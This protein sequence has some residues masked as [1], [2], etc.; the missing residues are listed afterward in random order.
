[1]TSAGDPQQVWNE[2]VSWCWDAALHRRPCLVHTC[3]LFALKCSHSP[4]GIDR[5]IHVLGTCRV[6]SVL[7]VQGIAGKWH[8]SHL[9]FPS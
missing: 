5:I 1:M 9:H 8:E 6:L 3:H 4:R 7:L 2:M